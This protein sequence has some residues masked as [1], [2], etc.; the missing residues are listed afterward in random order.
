MTNPLLPLVSIA[1]ADLEAGMTTAADVLI[2]ACLSLAFEA[3]ARRWCDARGLALIGHG[4]RA[5]PD[6]AEG[7]PVPPPTE[8]PR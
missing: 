7:A 4:F 3:E 5:R 1:R 6:L 8:R 2:L